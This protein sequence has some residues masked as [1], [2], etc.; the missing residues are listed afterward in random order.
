MA[1]LPN[2]VGQAPEAEQIAGGREGDA[3]LEAEPLARERLL[4]ER[5]E[6]GAAE[7]VEVGGHGMA[8]LVTG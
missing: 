3:V 4:G 5:G 6:R 1:P 2:R 8:G 7:G